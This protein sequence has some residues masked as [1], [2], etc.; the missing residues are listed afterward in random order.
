MKNTN[1]TDLSANLRNLRTIRLIAKVILIIFVAILA[2]SLSGC[3]DDDDQPVDSTELPVAAQTFIS[4]YYPAAGVS[5][6]VVSGNEYDVVLDNGTT[7]DFNMSGEWLEV[8]A[9]L[10]QTVPSGFYPSQIDSYVAQYGNG[11]GINEISKE[12]YGFEVELV[13]GVEFQFGPFGYPL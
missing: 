11:S 13:S 2:F 5:S 4:T 7:I 8:T 12:S 1:K 9:P 6:A 3:S 10:G